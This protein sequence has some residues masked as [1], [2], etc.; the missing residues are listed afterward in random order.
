MPDRD[1]LTISVLADI[2][3]ND[4]SR[5]RMRVPM[6]MNF[7]PYIDYLDDP[8]TNIDILSDTRKR[9]RKRYTK[10][11]SSSNHIFTMNSLRDLPESN[12]IQCNICSGTLSFC[13]KETHDSF[14]RICINVSNQKRP[15]YQVYSVFVYQSILT[16]DVMTNT[17]IYDKYT[18]NIIEAFECSTSLYFRCP[19]CLNEDSLNPIILSCDHCL[20]NQCFYQLI[21]ASSILCPICRHREQVETYL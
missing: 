9:Q 4:T 8:L 17:T 18:L 12:P 19:V 3:C 7:I 5:S 2:F 20:C 1:C 13:N 16:E 14:S 6:L 21:I 10:M 15:Y 11:S